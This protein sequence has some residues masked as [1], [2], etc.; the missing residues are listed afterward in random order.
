MGCDWYIHIQAL[1]SDNKWA[2]VYNFESKTR[3]GGRPI[4]DALRTVAAEHG[5]KGTYGIEFPTDTPFV[6]E[7]EEIYEDNYDELAAE[8]EQLKKLYDASGSPIT[9]PSAQLPKK[10]DH[11]EDEADTKDTPL[12]PMEVLSKRTSLRQKMKVVADRCKEGG[13]IGDYPAHHYFIMSQQDFEKFITFVP[14]CHDNTCYNTL[15]GPL[16]LWTEMMKTAIPNEGSPPWMDDDEEFIDCI[17]KDIESLQEAR[18]SGTQLAFGN[19]G[20]AAHKH[21]LPEDVKREVRRYLVTPRAKDMRIAIYD[22]EHNSKSIRDGDLRE[23]AN[24]CALM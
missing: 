11:D 16:G 6:V 7:D 4:R 17:T 15:L 21:S 1:G 5:A 2:T 12:S 14:K 22:D 24:G 8:L 9:S 23:R 20:V 3:C 10:R 13:K 19:L 18:S